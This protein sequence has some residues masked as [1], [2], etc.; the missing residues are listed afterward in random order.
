MNKV[1]PSFKMNKNNQ[2][3]I[4]RNSSKKNL[5]NNIMNKDFFG[6]REHKSNNIIKEKFQTEKSLKEETMIVNDNRVNTKKD[7]NIKEK[8]EHNMNNLQLIDLLH[9]KEDDHSTLVNKN[10]KLRSLVV[11]ASQKLNE[12]SEKMNTN[13]Q[14][15]VKEKETILKELDRITQNYQKYAHSYKN[16]SELEEKY[17]KLENDYEH[18]YNVLISYQDS[19]RYL[20]NK[21][22]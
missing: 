8:I 19:I 15:F 2:V 12:L 5:E 6:G 22:T 4:K 21:H 16:Y 11:Q 17:Q 14:L 18:N 13:E 20:S 3:I 7:I 10:H 9:K 1:L